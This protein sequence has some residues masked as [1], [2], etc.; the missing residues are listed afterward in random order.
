MLD[1]VTNQMWKEADYKIFVANSIV[2]NKI[3]FFI[4]KNVGSY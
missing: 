3:I 1:V 4:I 2:I